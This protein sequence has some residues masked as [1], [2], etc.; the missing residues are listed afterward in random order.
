MY[1]KKFFFTIASGNEWKQ[2]KTVESLNGETR[3][4]AEELMRVE[5]PEDEDGAVGALTPYR[6]ESNNYS[7][8]HTY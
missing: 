2:E 4:L 6:Y 5:S 3:I 8:P 7:L 1:F